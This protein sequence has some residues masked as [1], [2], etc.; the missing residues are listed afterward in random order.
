MTT[1]EQVYLTC[2]L[3][4]EPLI[5]WDRVSPSNSAIVYGETADC[6]RNKAYDLG[7]RCGSDYAND[8]HDTHDVIDICESCLAKNM[9]LSISASPA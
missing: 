1:H 4:N 6:A 7:W 9:T 8:T 5:D 2:N 3:C